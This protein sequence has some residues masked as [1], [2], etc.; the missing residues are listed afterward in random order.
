MGV[1]AR[2]E[3]ANAVMRALEP[4]LAKVKTVV[5]LASGKYRE[6]LEPQFRFRG[7]QVRVP[8]AKLR[9]GE[10]LAWLNARLP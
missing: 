2:R 7:I 10:Q 8:M 4:N 1:S 5:I 3:W 9:I 6:F